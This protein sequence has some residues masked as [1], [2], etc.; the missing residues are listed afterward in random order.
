MLR[1]AFRAFDFF[2]RDEHQFAVPHEQRPT[3]PARGPIHDGR[4]QPGADGAGD[5]NAGDAEW[6]LASVREVRG[7]RDDDFAWQ[8]HDGA[9]RGHEQRDERV[10][11]APQGVHVPVDDLFEHARWL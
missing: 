9:F 2:R 7:G 8:W 11:T 5:D 1:P 10:T 4:S 6:Y 3:C